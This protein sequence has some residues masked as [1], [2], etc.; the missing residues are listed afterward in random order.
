[1]DGNILI[2]PFVIS[3]GLSMT[4][5]GARGKTADEIMTALGYAIIGDKRCVSNFYLQYH[6]ILL[7]SLFMFFCHD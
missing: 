1:M 5:L 6:Q 4:L 7:S 3:S 2:S